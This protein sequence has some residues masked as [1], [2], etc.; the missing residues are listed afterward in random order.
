M[1]QHE[2]AIEELLAKDF[3]TIPD[4]IRSHARFRP[5]H[6]AFIQDGA[7]LDYQALDRRMDRVAAAL[8]RD[9]IKGDRDYRHLRL[10]I[11]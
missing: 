8:Q 10:Y 1:N 5:H 11:D 4:L 3:G 6:P 9:G 7:T 2:L